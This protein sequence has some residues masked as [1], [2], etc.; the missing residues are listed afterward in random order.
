M[1]SLSLLENTSYHSR[2]HARTQRKPWKPF[3]VDCHLDEIEQTC[4]FWSGFSDLYSLKETLKPAKTSA[5][6]LLLLANE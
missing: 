3:I 4:I 5:R 6:R 1:L 2:T